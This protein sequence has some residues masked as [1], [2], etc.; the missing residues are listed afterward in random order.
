MSMCRPLLGLPFGSFRGSCA[1]RR[2]CA[3]VPC[4]RVHLTRKLNP[5]RACQLEVLRQHAA[6]IVVV[7][8]AVAA[9]LVQEA[10]DADLTRRCLPELLPLSALRSWLRSEDGLFSLLSLCRFAAFGAA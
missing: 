2:A 9:K 8:A 7:P 1:C 6:P 3:S 5:L 10:P 4:R